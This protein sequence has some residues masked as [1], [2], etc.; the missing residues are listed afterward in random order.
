[1]EKI[2]S[3]YDWNNKFRKKN[4]NSI[5]LKSNNKNINSLGMPQEKFRSFLHNWVTKN[6][7]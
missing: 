4:L 7:S 6:L 3:Y 1:M 2:L 5:V